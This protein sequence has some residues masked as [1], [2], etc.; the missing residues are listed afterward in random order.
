[1][2]TLLSDT[3]LHDEL[4]S[5]KRHAD[6]LGQHK[7]KYSNSYAPPLEHRHKKPTLVNIAV[8]EPPA[9]ST[10]AEEP[11]NEAIT[12]TIKSIKPPLTFNLSAPLT[13][14]ISTLKAQLSTAESTAPAP[15]AQR[16][17][18]KGKAMGGDRLLKEFA[19]EEGSVVT[20][21]TAKPATP[22]P[23]TP[24]PVPSLSPAHP[25][26]EKHTHNRVPSLT[27]T[28]PI[29]STSAVPSLSINTSPEIPLPDEAPSSPTP[30]RFST[31]MSDPTLWIQAYELLKQQFGEGREAEAQ[32]AWEGWLSGSR[33]AISPGD[34]ALIRSRVGLSAMGGV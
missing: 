22:A 19:V 29:S 4:E 1:M 34:K 16:W 20:L 7:L 28:E 32:R 9:L 25:P 5:F 12:L 13:A 30:D 3:K 17:L 27:L 14:T 26:A 10:D 24:S 21:M 23:A 6:V 2:E 8:V 15:E 11:T 33:E 18:L 31:T